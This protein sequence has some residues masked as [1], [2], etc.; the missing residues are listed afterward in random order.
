MRIFL[1]EDDRTSR[2]IL[3]AILKKWGYDP[4]IAADG[5]TAWDILQRPDAP[6]LV[7]LD[8][9]MPGMDGIDV[10]RLIRKGESSNPP[11]VIMLTGKGEKRDIVQGLDAG[12]NDYICKPYDN[13]EL[14]ARIR[15]GQRMVELQAALVEARDTMEHQALHDALTGIFNR[16]AILETLRREISRARRENGTVSIGMLDI[17][18]FKKINDTHGHQVGDEVLVG[19]VRM[20]QRSLREYDVT[21]R[22]GGEEFLVIAPVPK[23]EPVESVFERVRSQVAGTA[24]ETSAGPISI[25]VSIG[26]VTGNGASTVDEMLRTADLALYRAKAEGRNR[27]CHSAG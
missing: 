26:T 6:R 16:R 5:A 4:V 12:A 3:T 23:E 2:S 1:A 11:Y 10:C 8:W 25:T 20:V 14:L 13:D 9:N 17:D 21:G 27:V 22:Y 18:F 15:V 24:L 19:F 7:L